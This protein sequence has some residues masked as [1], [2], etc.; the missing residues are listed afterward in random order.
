MFSRNFEIRNNANPPLNENTEIIL[1][2]RVLRLRGLSIIFRG[3]M[4]IR[5]ISLTVVEASPEVIPT[6]RVVRC[7][8]SKVCQRKVAVSFNSL[9]PLQTDRQ[10][11]CTVRIRPLP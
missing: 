2:A 11:V 8:N 4:D 10:A 5:F 1:T 9:T 6:R 3:P 7:R